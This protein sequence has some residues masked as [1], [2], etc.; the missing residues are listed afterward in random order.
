MPVAQYLTQLLGTQKQKKNNDINQGYITIG[1]IELSALLGCRIV[2]YAVSVHTQPFG[3]IA[4]KYI[5]RT[6]PLGSLTMLLI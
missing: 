5:L 2:G 3:T 6:Q 1:K 4:V